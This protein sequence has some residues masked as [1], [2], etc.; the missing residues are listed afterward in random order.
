MLI[1]RSHWIQAGFE[2]GTFRSG[3]ARSEICASVP[4]WA[5]HKKIKKLKIKIKNFNRASANF[6]VFVVAWPRT[7]WRN[8]IFRVPASSPTEAA[9]MR[10]SLINLRFT[11]VHPQSSQPLNCWNIAL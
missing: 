6:L 7:F 4:L 2:P 11:K 3:V 8:V 9:F 5:D 1:S 10:M